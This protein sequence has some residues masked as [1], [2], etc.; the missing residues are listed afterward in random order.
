MLKREKK[1]TN[2]RKAFIIPILLIFFILGSFVFFI[3]SRI[4]EE[5]SQSAIGNLSESLNLIT[6]MVEAL[7]QRDAEYQALIAEELALADDPDEYLKA[8][9]SSST[10][11][12]FS[13]IY[14]G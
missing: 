2:V 8:Y 7:Y 1:L 9:K 14:T 5:M 4:S 11:K 12:K 3:A 10:I 6:G 13:L